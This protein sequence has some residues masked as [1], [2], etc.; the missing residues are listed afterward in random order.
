M[1]S[2]AAFGETDRKG[3]MLQ[4]CFSR[5]VCPTQTTAAMSGLEGF[6]HAGSK[7]SSTHF[8]ADHA[9]FRPGLGHRRSG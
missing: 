2:L 3:F 1:P 7:E 6:I 8:P 4:L 9:R 5:S